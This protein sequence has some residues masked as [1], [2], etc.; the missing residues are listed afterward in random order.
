MAC[1]QI[2]NPDARAAPL[3]AA[4]D[5]A[6]PAAQCVLLPTLAR[7]GG[8]ASLAAVHRAM[9]SDEPNV[10]DAGYRALANWPDD[11]VAAELLEIAKTSDVPVYRIW[12]LR[13]FAR[14]VALPGARPPQASF[15][16]LTEAWELATRQ[17]DKELII[18]RL[19]AVRVPEALRLLLSFVD[20]PELRDA[21]VPAVFTLAKGL[22]QSHPDLARAALEKVRPLTEDPATLQQIPKVL[23]DIEARQPNRDP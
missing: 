2:P 10:R 22:S 8:E 16:M 18:S 12:S 11:T 19:A 23:R 3:L 21:A 5:D 7:I 13:A 20:R 14:V 1:E 6:E 9:Q 17:E 15:E 4:L